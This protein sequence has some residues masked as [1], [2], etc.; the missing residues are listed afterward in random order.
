MCNNGRESPD[1]FEFSAPLSYTEEDRT[2][3]WVGV[4]GYGDCI[5]TTAREGKRDEPGCA[6]SEVSAEP[7]PAAP[8][9][10]IGLN[11]NKAGME[12]LDKAK[13]NQIIIEASKGSKYYEN[14]LK[15]EEQVTRRVDRILTELR[16]ITPAQKAAALRA[17][18]KELESLEA[19]RELNRIIVHVDM[20]AFYASVE[21]R[22]DPRLKDV[23]MAVG[24]TAML[25]SIIQVGLMQGRSKMTRQK[26]DLM[27][28]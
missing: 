19:T 7:S 27:H 2:E 14:E 20:D 12:G 6:P 3:E 21:I 23:P 28:G 24:S 13:I 16:S 25:V 5:S 17:A 8:I 4:D 1:L 18:D 26:W 15:K 10:R 11:D 22:D 9:S